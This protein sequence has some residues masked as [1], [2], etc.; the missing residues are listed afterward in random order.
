MNNS[1]KSLCFEQQTQLIK[2]NLQKC[3][4]FTA[5]FMLNDSTSYKYN[6][7][8]TKNSVKQRDEYAAARSIT[9]VEAADFT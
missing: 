6:I 5:I 3:F 8:T 1:Q 4:V 9:S 2:P 7:K